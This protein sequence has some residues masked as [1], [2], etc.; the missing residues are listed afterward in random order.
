MIENQIKTVMVGKLIDKH[1]K[2]RKSLNV[3][4]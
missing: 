4:E 1:C 2:N 3:N